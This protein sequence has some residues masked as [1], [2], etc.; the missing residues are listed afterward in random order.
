MLI[1]LYRAILRSQADSLRS[2]VMY[3]SMLCLTCCIIS[4]ELEDVDADQLSGCQDSASFCLIVVWRNSDDSVLD[5]LFWNRQKRGQT[6]RTGE[7]L[8]KQK[9]VV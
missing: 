8:F 5:A 7:S 6:D 4:H 3:P 2:H 1:A 9:K